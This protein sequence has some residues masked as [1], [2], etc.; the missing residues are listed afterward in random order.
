MKHTHTHTHRN[1]SLGTLAE[2]ARQ[3][4]LQEALDAIEVIDTDQSSQ[5]NWRGGMRHGLDMAANAIRELM[6]GSS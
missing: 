6:K 1:L 4:T 2:L 5:M 3:E